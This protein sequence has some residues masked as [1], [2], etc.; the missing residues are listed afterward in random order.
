M[1]ALQCAPEDA[2]PPHQNAEGLL[3]LDA[4]VGLVKVERVLQ[5]AEPASGERAK[6]VALERVG[7]V[8]DNPEALRQLARLQGTR[9]GREVERAGVVGLSCSIEEHACEDVVVVAD[10]LAGVGVGGWLVSAC[11]WR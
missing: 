6:K 10:G 7:V 5:G 3:D 1:R 11:L 4:A 9:E 2:P 8:A